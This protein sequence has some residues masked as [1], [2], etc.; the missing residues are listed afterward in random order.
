MAKAC[1]DVLART[2]EAEGNEAENTTMVSRRPRTGILT[3]GKERKK[4]TMAEMEMPS[5]PP[6]VRRLVDYALS[7]NHGLQLCIQLRLSSL[8]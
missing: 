8:A 5:S 4:T 2:R 7:V 3:N 6:G 1:D